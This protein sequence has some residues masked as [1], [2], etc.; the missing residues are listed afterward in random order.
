MGRELSL[1]LSRKR[2]LSGV[3]A[4]VIGRIAVQGIAF[5]EICSRLHI[6][7]IADGRWENGNDRA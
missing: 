6:P 3:A 4:L 1:Q 5:P 7:E 2:T